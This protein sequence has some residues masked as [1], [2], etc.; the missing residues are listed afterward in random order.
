MRDFIA[1]LDSVWI[2]KGHGLSP[3]TEKGQRII[4][5][6]QQTDRLDPLLP[7][8]PSIIDRKCELKQW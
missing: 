6:K 4:W 8:Q 1:A 3:E 7:S 5:M 2:Q